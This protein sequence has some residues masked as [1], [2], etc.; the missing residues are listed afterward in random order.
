[1]EDTE[2]INIYIENFDIVD[3][4]RDPISPT[5]Y[6]R[7]DYTDYDVVNLMSRYGEIG[8]HTVTHT[9]LNNSTK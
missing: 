5:F 6:I 1:L 7:S 3:A 2:F 8:V 9:T 4:N